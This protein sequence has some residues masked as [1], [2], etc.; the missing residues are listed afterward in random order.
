MGMG[1]LIIQARSTTDALPLEGV[2]IYIRDL[3]GNLLYELITNENGNTE[4]V[5]LEAVD[6]A[7]SLDPSYTGQPYTSYDLLAKANGFNSLHIL[8]MQIF[9]GELAIQPI[10]LF[11]MIQNQR[12]S[13]IQEISM[14]K[15]GVQLTIPREQKGVT[16]SPR[17]FQQVIIPSPITI[18]LGAPT[19]TATDV[20][21][22]FTDYI[23]NVASSEIYPTWPKESLKSNIYAIIT[24]SLNRVFTQWYRSRGYEF[25]ITSNPAYD[26]YFVY[27][28][29]IYESISVIVDSI[30]NQYV[31]R[32]NQNSPYFTSFCSGSNVTCDGLSQ[33]G[34]VTLSNQ[35][36]N[37]L[38]IL[39]Y[40]YP[41]DVEIA[42]SNIIT[43]IVDAYPGTLLKIGSSG[44]SVELMQQYLTRIR[45]NY[46]GIPAITD[47]LGEFG[48][49]T[50][51]SVRF[52]QE[53][54]SLTVDGIIGKATWNKIS[55]I[56]VAVT[57]LAALDS[58]GT[59]LDVGT[60]PP[61]VILQS[62]S[63]GVDVITL[64]YML[65]FISEYYPTVP[66]LVQ[67][68]IFGEG[69]EN[70][71]KLFQ[72]MMELPETG[73]VDSQT[74]NAIYNV[75]WG[76]K[77][78]VPLVPANEV[79]EYLVQSGDTL[80]AIARK[81]ETTVKEL[82]LL[83]NL[84]SDKIYVGQ[85]L[86]IPNPPSET[87]FEYVVTSGDTLWL[88]AKLFNTTVNEIK[89]LNNMENDNLYVGQRLQIPGEQMIYTVQSGD[90]LWSIAQLHHSTVNTIKKINN[91][92]SDALSIGQKLRLPT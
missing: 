34:T 44:Q 4:Q 58:E 72:K 65:S 31:K 29:T 66:L 74:W 22:P 90:T 56:Y 13:M 9:D 35:G 76:I 68:G 62:G 24:F 8:D 2:S 48:A 71:V 77:N 70:A 15:H 33:W 92:T 7:L 73:V 49:S 10:T 46:P 5:E 45:K 54:F 69:T 38:E 43:N 16:I 89:T 53:L 87:G 18:H 6:K 27:G 21:V 84:T 30:F 32:P 40:Y 3:N 81:Y 51:A 23:K 25:D 63:T 26:Q 91:L 19:S 14:G 55:A 80:W 41:D 47:P 52:F 57:K 59:T 67:D 85:L 78:G 64:Q 39:R 36:M 86:L 82:L 83:N 11:P 42:E 79:F 17:I 88:L 20:Q 61:N 12:T 28:R 37:S 50:D 60:V 1:N 75:Y